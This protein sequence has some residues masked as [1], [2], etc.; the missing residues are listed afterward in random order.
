MWLLQ[1]LR[2]DVARRHP[3]E[4]PVEARERLLDHHPGD[5]LECLVPHLALVLAVDQEPPELRCRAGF[6]G[7][8]LD[9]AAGDQVERRDPFRRRAPDG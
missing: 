9:T 6:A 3:D 7:A 1:R 4:L 8:E 5:R 2:N